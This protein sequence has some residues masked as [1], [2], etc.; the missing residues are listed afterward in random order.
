[1]ELGAAFHEADAFADDGVSQH[2]AG[3]AV[4]N[5]ISDC[6]AERREIV[7]VTFDDAPA[8]GSPVSHQRHGHDVV[9]RAGDL[10]VVPVDDDRQARELL[11]DGKTT[12]LPHLTL[13]L[14]AVGHHNEGVPTA[15]SQTRAQRES[16]ARRE[17]LTEVAAGPLDARYRALHMALEDTAGLTKVGRELLSWEEPGAS[18]GGI[19]AWG[20]MAVA[21]HDSVAP[22][23]ARFVRAQVGATVEQ[24]IDFHRRHRTAGV[25]RSSKGRGCEHVTPG[26]A[27]ALGQRCDAVGRERPSEGVVGH[28]ISDERHGQAARAGKTRVHLDEWSVSIIPEEASLR[29]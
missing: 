25:A 29:A 1:M 16:H 21:D 24:R 2:Y 27:C 11:L 7:A 4:F 9:G 6:A 28:A 19:R 20:R 18:E 12:G 23:P 13:L 8:V 15:S 14:L 26:H 22:L 5:R 10:D 17:A 3:N